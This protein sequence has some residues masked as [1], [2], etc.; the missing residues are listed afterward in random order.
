[1][2]GV[3]SLPDAIYENAYENAKYDTAIGLG[4]KFSQH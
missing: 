4:H 3:I 1:M 2:H